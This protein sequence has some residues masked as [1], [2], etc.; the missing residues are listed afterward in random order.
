M[1]KTALFRSLHTQMVNTSD[2]ICEYEQTRGI[3]LK[4]PLVDNKKV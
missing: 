2:W 1:R 4:L 3:S